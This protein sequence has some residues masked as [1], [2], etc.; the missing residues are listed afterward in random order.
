MVE[1]FEPKVLLVVYDPRIQ[2]FDYRRLSQVLG[3]NQ[4]ESL[5]EALVEDINA[6]SYGIC[7][8]RV[9]ERLQ[10]DA[11]PIKE[12]GF[13]YSADS[14][15]DAWHGKGSFHS[16]DW[17]DYNHILEE[18]GGI[19]KINRGRIDELWLF[20][21]PY[22]GFYESRMVGPGSFWCNAPPLKGRSKLANPFVMMGFN[23]ERGVGEMLESYC[24]R[25]ESIMAHAYRDHRGSANIWERFTRIDKTHTG[26]AEVG[27]VHFAPNSRR[28]YDW[29]NLSPVPS[30]CDTWLKFPDLMGR[31]RIVDC[32]DWGNGDARKHHLWWLKHIPHASGSTSGLSNNWWTYIVEPNRAN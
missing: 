5:I 20:A 25:V 7:N 3:W 18:V 24:H 30:R 15:L 17:A 2:S 21:F 4:V 13:R 14:Y 31:P 26:H 9:A 19:D 1:R 11:F 22:G 29:G 10:I 28:D 23:Y 6:A 12:D 27:T 32:R 16:P 8:Y